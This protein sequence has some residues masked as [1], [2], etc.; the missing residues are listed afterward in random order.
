MNKAI[1][2]LLIVIMLAAAVPAA[3]AAAAL[4][5]TPTAKSA[6]DKMLAA[7]DPAL[8]G[9]IRSLYNEHLDLQRQAAERDNRIQS[10]HKVNEETLTALRKQIKLIDTDKLNRLDQ[11]AK[12]ARERYKPLF[13]LY[14]SL[15]QQI[16]AAKPLK[17]KELNAVLRMQA[18]SVQSAIQLARADI[19]L[20]E[21]ALKTA[22]ESAAKTIKLIRGT[23]AEIDPV[24]ARIKAEKSSVSSIQKSVSPVWKGFTQAVKKND[25]KGACNMLA[26]VVSQSRQIVV[27]KQRVHTLE[28]K[29]SEIINKA[30]A[31]IPPHAK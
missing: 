15:N 9:Q 10:L 20:K 29:I 3:A 4:E 23:L 6:Y 26:S 14:T 8:S 11:Q 5:L 2:G 17:N 25:V 21:A 30:K 27:L 19:R 13:A 28:S 18:D 16:A 22:K 1:A 31:Q 12:Q 24:K 7:A